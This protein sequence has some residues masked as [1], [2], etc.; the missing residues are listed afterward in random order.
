MENIKFPQIEIHVCISTGAGHCVS[1]LNTAAR[2]EY[3]KNEGINKQ[4]V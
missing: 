1:K 2:V 3:S 4:M